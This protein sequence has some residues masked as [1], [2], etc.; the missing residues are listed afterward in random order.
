MN[1]WNWEEHLPLLVGASAT[2]F[3]A[4]RLFSVAS[5]EPE[6]AYEILQANGTSTVIIGSVI[7]LL[8]PALIAAAIICW[9]AYV[10]TGKE[11]RQRRYRL[12]MA[13]ELSVGFGLFLT[14]A[15]V[16]VG[17]PAIV[18]LAVL[19]LH[20]IR[21]WRSKQRGEDREERARRV[22][23]ESASL[24]SLAKRPS[25]VLSV[26][27]VAVYVFFS[28]SWLPSERVSIRGAE[29]TETGYILSAT[30]DDITML[31]P[32]S[33]GNIVRHVDPHLVIKRMPCDRNPDSL[34]P[35]L[36]LIFHFRSPYAKC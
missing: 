12:L 9:Q 17:V 3:I 36:A 4:I 27:L 26:L 24:T 10:S 30:S 18:A 8:G 15:L 21:R 35:P 31:I 19:E 22:T 28:P 16:F 13:L 34:K 14:P 33:A 1:V 25:V 7:S 32:T 6:T 20:L 23:K 2:V 29:R 5:F 11:R